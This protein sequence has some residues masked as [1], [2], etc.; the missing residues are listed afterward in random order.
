MLFRSLF[1]ILFNAPDLALTQLVIETITTALFLLAFTHLP[2]LTKER[3][4]P[5][6][7]W[8]K[9]IISVSV[10]SIFVIVALIV[11]G[12]LSTEKISLFFE[13]SELLMGGHNI[14]NAILGDFRAFDT[15]LEV[16]VLMIAGIGVYT[17]V[18]SKIKKEGT[19]E[20]K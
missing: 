4:S 2:K 8:L 9:V 18:K 7:R 11:N 5:I 6:G 19:H 13:D 17:L 16:V 1:F 15:M 10:G 20:N 3:N 12:S 14:V